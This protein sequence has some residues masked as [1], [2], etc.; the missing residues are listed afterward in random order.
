MTTRLMHL[1]KPWT[2]EGFPPDD[3]RGVAVLGVDD[4]TAVCTCSEH[5]N[6]DGSVGWHA[7]GHAPECAQAQPAGVKSVTGGAADS[8]AC[9]CSDEWKGQG[10]QKSC[11]KRETVQPC[12]CKALKWTDEGHSPDCVSQKVVEAETETETTE[13]R[14]RRS[15]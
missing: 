8:V 12:T 10:H 2:G 3:P 15:R 5:E 7:E 14:S 6:D 1:G 13:K 9:T 4:A 11:P